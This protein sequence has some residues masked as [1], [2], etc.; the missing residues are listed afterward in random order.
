[1]R[2][3]RN[4]LKSPDFGVKL[5]IGS[6]IV[7]G[8]HSYFVFSSLSNYGVIPKII[9]SA[10]YAT[11]LSCAILY[12]T[13]I[14]KRKVALRFQFFESAINLYYFFNVISEMIVSGEI[15][16]SQIILRSIMAIGIS[17]MM[18]YIIYEYAGSLDVD[19]V[20]ENTPQILSP[21]EKKKIRDDAKR[22]LLKQINSMEDIKKFNKKY[23]NNGK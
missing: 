20:G 17:I 13:M 22:D 3:F 2:K 15:N 7:Q 9:S 5:L 1:M 23:F 11:I 10:F 18:P 21:Y 4:Y 14:N 6:V 12:Y 8:F 19:E 16:W